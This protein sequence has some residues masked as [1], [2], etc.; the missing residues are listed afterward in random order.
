MFKKL[1][2]VLDIVINN[3][4]I[5]KLLIFFSNEYYKYKKTASNKPN[6]VVSLNFNIA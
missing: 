1:Y 4:H 5:P 3:I 2:F 6:N